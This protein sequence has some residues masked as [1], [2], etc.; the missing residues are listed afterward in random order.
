MTSFKKCGGAWPLWLPP[1][2][3]YA[4]GKSRT[5]LSESDCLCDYI[6]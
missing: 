6:T 4:S 5:V 2:Y 1:G 3:A